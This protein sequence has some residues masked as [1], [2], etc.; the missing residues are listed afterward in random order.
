MPQKLTVSDYKYYMIPNLKGEYRFREM[1]GNIFR[2][3]RKTFDA[4][5]KRMPPK[6]LAKIIE[7][8]GI[9]SVE[10]VE[11]GEHMLVFEVFDDLRAEVADLPV[12]RQAILIKHLLDENKLFRKLLDDNNIEIPK[13]S[14]NDS[15]RD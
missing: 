12:P 5:M 1:Q 6:S 7:I 4:I 3:P 11:T 10:R 9:A 13:E 15:S 2:R 8:Y 14:K